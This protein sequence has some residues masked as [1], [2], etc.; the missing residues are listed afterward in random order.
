MGETALA[1]MSL[2]AARPQ[3]L[4]TTCETRQVPIDRQDHK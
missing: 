3:E 1:V 2:L 4:D